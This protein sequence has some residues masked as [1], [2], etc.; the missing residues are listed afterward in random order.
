MSIAQRLEQITHNAAVLA[1]EAG[2]KFTVASRADVDAL[3]RKA[4]W[5]PVKNFGK[6]ITWHPKGQQGMQFVQYRSTR[7]KN[8][9]DP[10]VLVK[11]LFDKN[12]PPYSTLTLREHNTIFVIEYK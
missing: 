5:R 8:W 6:L 10:T 2:N 1:Y 3:L 9:I 12:S 7:K 11:G 4:G